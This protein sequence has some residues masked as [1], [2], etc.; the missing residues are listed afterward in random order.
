MELLKDPNNTRVCKGLPLPPQRPL[1]QELLFPKTGI[2]LPLLKDFLRKE[3]R[4]AFEDYVRIVR[5]ATAIFRTFSLIK[6]HSRT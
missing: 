5:E 2:N 4:L 1:R 3:G 6:G